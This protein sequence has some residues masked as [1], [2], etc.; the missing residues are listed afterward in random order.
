MLDVDDRRFSGREAKDL[1]GERLELFRRKNNSVELSAHVRR[2]H[3]MTSM[4]L[5]NA[6]GAFAGAETP[7]HGIPFELRTGVYRTVLESP[8]ATSLPPSN[9]FVANCSERS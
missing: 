3:V 6:A 2:I 9:D 7:C 5:H 8:S 1:L 4:S